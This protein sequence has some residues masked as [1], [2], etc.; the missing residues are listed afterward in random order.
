MTVPEVKA[1]HICFAVRDLNSAMDRFRS[2]LGV[3]LWRLHE[4]RPNGTRPAYGYG[5]GQTWELFEAKGEGTTTIHRFLAEHGEGV[6]HIGFWA[7]DV[8]A[9]VEAALDAGA[10]LVTASQDAQGIS[11]VQLQPRSRVGEEQ[12]G[13]LGMTT[14]LDAGFGGTLIEYLGY[15]GETFLHDWLGDDY[16]R[17]VIP[18]PWRSPSRP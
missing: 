6:Q 10:S 1:F 16:D 7:E 14:F 2:I 9:A 15:A 11:T 18:P 13:R 3:D 17:M 5:A 12:L 8:R 4:P